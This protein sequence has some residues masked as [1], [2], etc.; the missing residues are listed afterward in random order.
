MSHST[1]TGLDAL[2][3]GGHR[4]RARAIA[5]IKAAHAGIFAD[6]LSQQLY[7]D[8]LSSDWVPE[9]IPFVCFNTHSGNV[10]ISGGYAGYDALMLNDNGL[11]EAWVSTPYS[12]IEGFLSELIEDVNNP[13]ASAREY[14]W[15]DDEDVEYIRGLESKLS[16]Y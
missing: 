10:W 13:T 14:D 1:Y 15:S 6:A 4:E 2:K 8:C 9:N 5:L 7:D 12:G 3:F 16:D 11:V